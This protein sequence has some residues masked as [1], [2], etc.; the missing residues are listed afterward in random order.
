[1]I[2]LFGVLLLTSF[3]MTI[4]F[5]SWN[6]GPSFSCDAQGLSKATQIFERKE[7]VRPNAAEREMGKLTK[8]IGADGGQVTIRELTQEWISATDGPDPR[9]CRRLRESLHRLN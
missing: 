9:A 5:Y 7:I 4:A 6:Q 8:R 2:R 3:A 1:M